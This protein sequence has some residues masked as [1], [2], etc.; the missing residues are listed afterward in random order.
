[1]DKYLSPYHS[2]IKLEIK[3]VSTNE[4]FEPIINIRNLRQAHGN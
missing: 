1:M 3:V 4:R 2:V